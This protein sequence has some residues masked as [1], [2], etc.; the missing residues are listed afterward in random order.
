MGMTKAQLAEREDAIKKLQDILG[1]GD[2]VYTIL[3]HVSSSGM[4]RVIS[5]V[6]ID[7]SQGIRNLDFLIEKLGIYKRTPASSR[8]DGLKVGGTGMDM[9]FAVV[10]DLAMTL[11]KDGYALKQAWL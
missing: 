3:R 4:S 7:E 5:V 9:G 8:H 2:K 10:Y 6:V 11:F 1:P